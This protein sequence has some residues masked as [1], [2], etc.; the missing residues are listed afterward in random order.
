MTGTSPIQ[1]VYSEDRAADASTGVRSDLETM[2]LPL[3]PEDPGL[4]VFTTDIDGYEVTMKTTHPDGRIA[5]ASDRKILN[6]LAA[7]IAAM[8]A[9]GHVP[10]RHIEVHVRSLVEDIA[11]SGVTGGSDHARIT[12]RLERL[13]STWITTEMPIGDDTS[14]KRHFRWID[15]FEVDLQETPGLQRVTRLKIS[16][17][18]DAFRWITRN[19]GFHIS[20]ERFHALTSS[21]SSIWR[22]YEICLARLVRNGGEPVHV[23]IDDLRRRIPI[24]SP[25]KLF[26]SRTLKTS[27]RAIS[28][29]T[30]MARVLRLSL[31]RKTDS[32]YEELPAGK[33]AELDTLY[34]EVVK[35]PDPLPETS[36]LIPDEETGLIE[37]CDTLT[38]EPDDDD[39]PILPIPME[40]SMPRR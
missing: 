27:M 39:Q 36:R 1:L 30:Q 14:R 21:R 24:A 40:A 9:S 35:G 20:T 31:V 3:F 10:S 19:E 26:R 15:A 4:H 28:G 33:R 17:S 5:T 6:V 12:E 13:A 25:L 16:L 23:H 2:L 38:L 29:N 18:I 34:I 7:R 37:P 8:I 32:G 11:C 22:I